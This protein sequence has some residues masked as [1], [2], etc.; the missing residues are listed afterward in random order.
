MLN[1]DRF[2]LWNFGYLSSDEIL[3]KQ[4]QIISTADTGMGHIECGLLKCCQV[5]FIMEISVLLAHIAIS[6]AIL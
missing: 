1:R 5:T 4:R 3:R 2:Q 6:I